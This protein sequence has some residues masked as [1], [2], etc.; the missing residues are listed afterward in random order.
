MGISMQWNDKARRLSLDLAKG[1]KF[2]GQRKLDVVM[3]GTTN[4]QSI[5][6]SGRPITIRL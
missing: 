4:Q 6:F 1:S 2:L 3:A 5:S